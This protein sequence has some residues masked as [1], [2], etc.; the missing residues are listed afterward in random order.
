M[1]LEKYDILINFPS[2]K[3]V[4]RIIST[5]SLGPYLTY[6]KNKCIDIT[7]KLMEHKRKIKFRLGAVFY[8]EPIDCFNDVHSFF[9]LLLILKN[10]K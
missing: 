7:K 8:K 5:C 2:C 6:T 10:Y 9:L 3:I 4:Y 1:K